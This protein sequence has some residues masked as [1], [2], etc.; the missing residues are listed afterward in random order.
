MAAVGQDLHP[1]LGQM[2][3]DVQARGLPITPQ[4]QDGSLRP[5]R[6]QQRLRVA[7][8]DQSRLDM[9]GLPSPPFVDHAPERHADLIGAAPR[10]GEQTLKP[11]AL[12]GEDAPGPDGGDVIAPARQVMHGPRLARP[13]NIEKVAA[14]HRRGENAIGMQ[15]QEIGDHEPA[16]RQPHEVS[17]PQPEPVHHRRQVIGMAE[18]LAFDRIGR[19]P[20]SAQVVANDPI[21][22][23]QGRE[24]RLPLG[25]IEAVPMEKDHGLAPPRFLDIEV[26]ETAAAHALGDGVLNGGTRH[27]RVDARSQERIVAE[28]PGA[29]EIGLGQDDAPKIGRP[30]PPDIGSGPARR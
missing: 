2:G 5:G 18:R 3:L 27:R 6:L 4:D 17:A 15:R 23:A 26:V 11:I 1:R 13:R 30:V 12:E 16:Q 7:T 22:L 25:A 19:S 20:V 9:Q 10:R 21:A 8:Q 14:G 28:R 24:L 29:L